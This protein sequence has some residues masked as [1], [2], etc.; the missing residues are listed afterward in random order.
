M[1]SGIATAAKAINPHIKIIAA[2]PC[3]RN[4]AADVAACLKH[5]QLV[6]AFPKP[7]TICDGLQARLGPINWAIVQN[8]VDDV[9]VVSEEEVVAAM[10][11][12]I[13]RMKV[14]VE[15]SGAAGLAA[16]LAMKGRPEFEGLKKV[17]VLLC[18]GNLD[19]ESRIEGFW[20]KWLL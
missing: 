2:E 5:R 11:L 3:G 17:G 18:G 15:P 6:I 12:C 7:K 19:L 1:I 14:V 16:V 8:L 9:V 4:N 10:R 13:E 20:E